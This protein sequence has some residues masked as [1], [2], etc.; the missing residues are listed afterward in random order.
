MRRVKHLEALMKANDRRYTEVNQEREKAL[1]I[2]KAG[3]EKALVLARSLQDYKDEKA[4]ELRSQIER[5]RG[6]YVTHTDL[7]GAIEKIEATLKPVVAYVEGQRGRSS[8]LNA[9]WGYLLG[10][11]TFVATGLAILGFL[12]K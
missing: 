6:T 5:E 1:L 8:G 4:N 10:A 7:T 12:V 2:E 11:A 3:N 9:G